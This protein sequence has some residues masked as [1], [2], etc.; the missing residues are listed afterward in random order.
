M[1]EDVR[2]RTIEQLSLPSLLSNLVMR[3][4][5]IAQG[6]FSMEERKKEADKKKE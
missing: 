1:G 4:C 2:Q 6:S 3:A 5:V